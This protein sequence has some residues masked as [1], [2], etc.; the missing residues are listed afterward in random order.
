MTDDRLEQRESTWS[1]PSRWHGC[2]FLVFTV[3]AV[4]STGYTG[5][6]EY[7]NPENKG[8]YDRACAKSVSKLTL[9]F[10]RAISFS[11][12]SRAGG[13]PYS[14]VLVFPAQAGNHTVLFSSF[15]RRRET[16]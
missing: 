12:L 15:P 1:V 11:R 3:M 10:A 9:P 6:E 2:Y 16:I 8:F 5:R 4:L 13:K 14:L 7:H